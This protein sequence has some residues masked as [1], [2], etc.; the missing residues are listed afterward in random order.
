MNNKIDQNTIIKI[1]NELLTYSKDKPHDIFRFSNAQKW[2]I[3]FKHGQVLL[4]INDVHGI[5]IKTSIQV[6]YKYLK[7]TFNNNGEV[8]V[9]LYSLQ[10]T[11]QNIHSFTELYK[12]ANTFL[13][14]SKT[15]VLKTI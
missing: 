15:R 7:R 10:Y 5:E 3:W 13:K 14:N 8:N 4:Y 9:E 6:F 1:L 11:D 2:T 12:E